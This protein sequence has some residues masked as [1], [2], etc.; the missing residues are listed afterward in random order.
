MLVATLQYQYIILWLSNI[1]YFHGMNF[2]PSVAVWLFEMAGELGLNFHSNNFK[3]N[4]TTVNNLTNNF[5]EVDL[6][7]MNSSF[8]RD[9]FQAHNSLLMHG[10]YT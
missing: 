8:K 4:F 5:V 9:I 3:F 10:K 2:K 1:A 6:K 7:I